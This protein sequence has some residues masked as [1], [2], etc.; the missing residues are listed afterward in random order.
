MRHPVYRTYFFQKDVLITCDV[1]PFKHP[2][3]DPT[4]DGWIKEFIKQK[5]SSGLFWAVSQGCREKKK[6]CHTYATFW[7]GFFNFSWEKKI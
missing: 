6:K 1:L 2:N 3:R 5:G 7:G 4:R